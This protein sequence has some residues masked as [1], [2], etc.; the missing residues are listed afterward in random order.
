VQRHAMRAWEEG[1]DFPTLVRAD[2]ELAERVQLDSVFDV[3]VYTRHVDTVF[4]R[5]R[6]LVRSEAPAHA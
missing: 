5:L 1:L 4:E 2:P 6:T 3:G